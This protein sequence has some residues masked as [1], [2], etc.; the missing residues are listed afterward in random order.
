LRRCATD[1]L[2]LLS[3]TAQTSAFRL[4][5]PTNKIIPDDTAADQ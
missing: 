2:L 5:N 3:E 4:G 1:Y